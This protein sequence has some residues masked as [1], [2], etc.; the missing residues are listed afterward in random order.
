[1]DGRMGGRTDQDWPP[2]EE[3]TDV[4]V[5]RR[6]RAP[7]VLVL[8]AVVITRLLPACGAAAARPRWNTLEFAREASISGPVAWTSSASAVNCPGVINT[9]S[10]ADTSAQQLP[11]GPTT[12]L[13][14]S[15]STSAGSGLQHNY[16]TIILTPALSLCSVLMLAHGRQRSTQMKHPFSD[17]ADT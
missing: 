16:F 17:E 8:A 7:P 10:G 4:V 12:A 2:E 1:M 5:C 6:V 3:Q 11:R 9:L 15:P 14:L 13:L